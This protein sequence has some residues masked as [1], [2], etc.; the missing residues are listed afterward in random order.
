MDKS[1]DV[2]S[3]TL[4]TLST[5]TKP[6]VLLIV[7][8]QP[9]NIHVLT[10]AFQDEYQIKVAKS[11]EL[12][13]KIARQIQPDLILLDIVMPGID[14]YEVCLHL[15][16]D[17]ATM[18]IPVIFVTGKTESHDELRGLEMGAV[19]YITKPF[20]IPIVRARVHTHIRLKQQAD[21]LE[22]LAAIDGLTHIPNRRQAD[23]VLATEWKRAQRGQIPLSVMMIDIDCFKQ[24]NDHYG[25]A[26]GDDCLQRVAH[27]LSSALLRPADLMARY[28]GE[29]FIAVLPET[30]LD[31]A[32]CVGERLRDMVHQLSIPH[33]KSTNNDLV[34]VSLGVSSIIP[35]DTMTLE[36]LLVMADKLLYQAKKNG[37]N[38]V[39]AGDMIS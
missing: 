26:A 38:T 21:L 27:T 11:G 36:Q 16:E 2:N 18:N 12:A 25:H 17:A 31:A 6:P 28:G 9:A 35:T 20:N 22:N 3:S 10:N 37:R 34:S 15:K 32:Q 7:D 30:P 33:E 19:D 24:Y 23:Q 8:D 1:S 14:G 13:L 5:V 29:E 4:Y 39:V